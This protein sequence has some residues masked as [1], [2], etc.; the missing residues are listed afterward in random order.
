MVNNKNREENSKE[1]K[2]SKLLALFMVLVYLVLY[3]T[4]ND[5]F[6]K[7]ASSLWKMTVQ[8]SPYLVLIFLLMFLS[9]FF[10]TPEKAK[11]IFGNN[12]GLKAVIITSVA[13]ILSVGPSYVWFP[14]LHDL[15][16]H[17]ITNKLVAV[18]MYNR[19]IKLQ[20]L[21]VMV[22]YFGLKYTITFSIILFVFSFFIG[23]IVGRIVPD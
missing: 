2:I 11:K 6:S 20:I 5:F 7:S 16:Q 3:F 14:L 15:K 21:P 10:I 9:A 18:F 22:F 4:D 19:A 12:S 23:E 8:L 1:G 17:G 13:G